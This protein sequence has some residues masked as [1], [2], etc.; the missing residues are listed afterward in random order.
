MKAG[1]L[2]SGRKRDRN[3]S[4][5]RGFPCDTPAV[6]ERQ[7][8]RRIADLEV[9]AEKLGALVDSGAD[10]MF[11]A[12]DQR[13]GE[14]EAT[15]RQFVVAE[16]RFNDRI[17]SLEA[18]LASAREEALREATAAVEAINADHWATTGGIKARAV[19]PFTSAY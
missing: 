16:K 8:G 13:I 11:S 5:G 3:A 12:A 18:Q 4:P 6:V 7:P 17:A 15:V 9:R 10:A 19:P 1:G 2:K 14:L